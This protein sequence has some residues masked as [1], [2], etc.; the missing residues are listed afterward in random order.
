MKSKRSHRV[1][2][3][4]ILCD[5]LILAVCAFASLLTKYAPKIEPAVLSDTLMWLPALVLIYLLVFV[6]FG[7]YRVLWKYADSYQMLKQAMAAVVGFGVTFISNLVLTFIKD[8]RPLSNNYLIT[9]GMYSVAA[10]LISRILMQNIGRHKLAGELNPSVDGRRVLVVGAGDAG[11]HIVEM[12]QDAAGSMG[13]IAVIVD[14]DP[15]KRGFR[16]GDVTVSGSVDDIPT[17]VDSED[18]SDIIIALPTASK[19]RLGEITRLCIGTG[20]YVRVMDRLKHID[21]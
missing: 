8:Y 15:G 16:I 18:I 19:E 2:V 12:F 13:T 3:A 10:I 1:K 20:C 11:S 5:A 14:D 17:L 7:M 4:L 21:K 9:Y 6:V